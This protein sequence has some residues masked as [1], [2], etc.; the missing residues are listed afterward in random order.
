MQ[1]E[2]NNAE[3][4]FTAGKIYK[5]A[6]IHNHYGGNR[7]S[8][9]RS[10]QNFPLYSFFLENLG[11]STGIETNG[12][13]KIFFSYTGEG[14]IGDMEFVKGNLAL[15]EHLKMGRRIFYSSKHKRLLSDMKGIGIV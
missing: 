10:L 12:R 2:V 1:P 4:F 7:Q 11:I 5:R 14:Q 13:M 15:R 9:F 8:E 6:V 3:P